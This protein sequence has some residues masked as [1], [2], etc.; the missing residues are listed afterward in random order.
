MLS[1]Q[2]REYKNEVKTMVVEEK[3]PTL[4]NRRLSVKMVLRP[5]DKRQIDIDNRIKAVLDSLQEAGVFVDDWQVDFLQIARGEP[6][7]HGAIYVTL[8]TIGDEEIPST[9]APVSV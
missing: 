4:G 7:R 5:R 2:G 6:V 8:E 9:S 3:I 1:K